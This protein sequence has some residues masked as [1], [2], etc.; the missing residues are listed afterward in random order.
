MVEHNLEDSEP[1]HQ[2]ALA[3][4]GT[5]FKDK[6]ER[7]SYSWETRLEVEFIFMFLVDAAFS[8]EQ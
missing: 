1:A 4:A 2:E 6:A 5:N 3:H 8:R 7:R